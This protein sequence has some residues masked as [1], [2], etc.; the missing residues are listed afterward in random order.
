M[1]DVINENINQ[2]E[3]KPYYIYIHTCPNRKA[4]VGLSKSPKQ[5]WNNGEGYKGNKEFYNAIQR[6]GWENIKHEIVAE[7]NYGWVAR[8]IEKKLISKYKKNGRAYNIVN[9]EKPAYVSQ[10]KIPLKKVAKYNKNG[11]LIKT[12]NSL[13]EAWLDGNPNPEYIRSCC[14]GRIK[15]TGGFVWKFI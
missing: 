15:T 5:R 2:R 13:R 3:D 10:R 9:E 11:E 12:Y 6:Y 1:R 4:Y 8:G 14:K 7:S